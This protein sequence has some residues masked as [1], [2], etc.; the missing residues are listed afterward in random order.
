MS[1]QLLI[2]TRNINVDGVSEWVWPK[3][4]KGAFGSENDGP[5]RDWLKGHKQAYFETIKDFDTIVTAGANCGMYTRFYSQL[6][7][8][9]YAFEPDPLNFHCMV[10][11]NQYDNVIKFNCALGDKNG[12]VGLNNSSTGNVGTHSINNTIDSKLYIQMLTIDSLNL[13][14]CSCIQLDVEGYELPCINGA[15]ETIARF[16]P[17]IITEK[18]KDEQFMQALGYKYHKQSY[19]DHI[20]IPI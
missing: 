5:M 14:N 18:F 6:F 12:T 8:H 13:E 4:D 17:V 9:V 1:Y 11:N 10:N 20:F 19:S 2:E 16:K 7:K 3:S 15:L